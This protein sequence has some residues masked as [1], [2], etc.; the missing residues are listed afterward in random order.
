M[1]LSELDVK[2][3]MALDQS[4]REMEGHTTSL[5]LLASLSNE[6]L[7]VAIQHASCGDLVRKAC[8]MVAEQCIPNVRERGETESE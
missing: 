2:I 5:L 1:E 3:Q 4:W 8:A 7:A 6:K